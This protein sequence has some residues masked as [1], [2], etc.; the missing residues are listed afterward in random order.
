MILRAKDDR[1]IHT[2]NKETIEQLFLQKNISLAPFLPLASFSEI[3]C[4][5]QK[6]ITEERKHKIDHIL[7][8]RLTSIE[9][10]CESPTDIHNAF[11]IVRTCEALGVTNIH[12]IDH[13]LRRKE[14]RGTMQGSGVWSSI[15][16][17]K[18]FNDFCHKRKTI[19][20]LIGI[21]PKAEKPISEI[22]IEGPLCLLFGNEQRGLSDGAKK[23]CDMLCTIPMFGMT[24]SFNLSVSA[25]I[26]L[27]EVTKRKRTFLQAR[28]DISKE[29]K[30]AEMVRA[31]IRTLGYD[32][33]L[34]IVRGHIVQQQEKDEKKNSCEIF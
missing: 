27:Y 5:L 18:T 13:E 14:G 25:G 16:F 17:Y 8:R 31:Y 2:M 11:A 21:D 30:Q 34:R 23:T 26:T 4:I 12:I 29:E 6:Y 20:S 1:K 19:Y 32:T 22:S 10:A 9:V 7:D 15:Q 28:K 3:A 24:Q 33:A